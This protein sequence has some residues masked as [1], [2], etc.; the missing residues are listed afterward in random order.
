MIEI[1]SASQEVGTIAVTPRWRPLGA[2]AV[3]TVLTLRKRKPTDGPVG[4]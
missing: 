4:A 2:R 1:K 3:I